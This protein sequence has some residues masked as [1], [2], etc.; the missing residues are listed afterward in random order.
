MS[1]LRSKGFR[2]LEN[3]YKN[4]SDDEIFTLARDSINQVISTK[5]LPPQ[6][7]SVLML[8]GAKV[9]IDS[10]GILHY[11]EKELIDFIMA[12]TFGDDIDEIHDKLCYPVVY[13]DFLLVDRVSQLGAEVAIPFLNYI[14]CFAYIDG[15][16]DDC[17]AEI[18]DNIFD[19]VYIEDFFNT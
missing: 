16:I 14:L 6:M 11:K 12:D 9:G 13:M 8:L 17:T 18:L 19:I 2:E 3:K 5:K 7:D 4:L 15:V 10:D 1:S